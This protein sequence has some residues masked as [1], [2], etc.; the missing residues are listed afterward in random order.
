MVVVDFFELQWC[1]KS[2]RPSMRTVVALLY[3]HF[4]ACRV[5]FGDYKMIPLIL[6][7]FLFTKRRCWG[8]GG[9]VIWLCVR[10][11]ISFK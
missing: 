9:V 3:C 5:F 7:L 10:L 1:G 6:W 8:R 4:L 2:G 11:A